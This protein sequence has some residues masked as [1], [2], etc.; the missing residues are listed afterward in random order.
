MSVDEK[1]RAMYRIIAYLHDCMRRGVRADDDMWGCGALGIG[2]SEW[3]EVVALLRLNGFI[4]GVRLEWFGTERIPSAVLVEC[5]RVT[6]AGVAFATQNL[7]M[8]QAE[9]FLRESGS[10]V[11]FI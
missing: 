9:A 3:R 6:A 4:E 10:P 2:Y 5:P 8:V 7:D 11:P 1:A